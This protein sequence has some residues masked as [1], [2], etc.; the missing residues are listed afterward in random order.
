M[1]SACPSGLQLARWEAGVA[2]GEQR[3]EWLAEHSRGCA[4]CAALIA[5]IV[6]ARRELFPR[7]S[8]AHIAAA[9]Q[10]VIAAAAQQRAQRS[11]RW[12]R[13]RL[14]AGLSLLGAITTATTLPSRDSAPSPVLSPEAPATQAAVGKNGHL[15]LQAFWQRGDVVVNVDEGFAFLAGDRLRFSYSAPAVGHLMI[16]GVDDRGQIVPYYGEGSLSSIPVEAGTKAL[17]PGSVKVEQHHGNQR[18]FA[19]W[20]AEPIDVTKVK[21][22]VKQAM[23]GGDIAR[24]ATLNVAVE[25]ASVLLRLP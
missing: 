2:V 18:I 5:E 22:A 20:A 15:A 19:L 21:V 17:L 14:L 16:F 1:M 8:T 11:G 4:R 7:Q 9:A 6:A 23:L 25:Q 13:F 3:Q 12:R 24:M 10:T